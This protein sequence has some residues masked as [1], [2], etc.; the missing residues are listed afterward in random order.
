MLFAAR[1]LRRFL[2]LGLL[3]PAAALLAGCAARPAGPQKPREYLVYV[4]TNIDSEQDN[5]VF[6][7]RLSPATG[8]LT[9]VAGYSAGAKPTY[10]TLTADRRFLYAVSETGTFRGAAGGGVSALAVDRRTGALA[11]L[12]QQPSTGASPCYVSLDHT[13]KNLLVANYMGGNVAVLPVAADGQLGAPTATDQHTGSG[14]HKNQ[15]TPHAHCFLPDPANT[16]AF[17]ADLGTD[18]VVGYRLTPAQGQLARLPEPAFAAR[19]GAGPRHLVFHPNGRRAYLINELNSTLTT[20][21]YDPAAGHFTELQTVSALPAGYAGPNAC[22]DVH[23]G[24]DGRF[25]YASN[26]G[27]NSI[28]VFAIDAAAGTLTPVQDVDTQG[29][30]PRNFALDPSGRLLLVA[31]QNSNSV[32]TFRVDPS[33]G[34]LTPTGQTVSVPTP[35]VV[36][37]VEDFTR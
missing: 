31:N 21:A 36:Q 2:T 27:H 14:P 3:G 30:T 20:L 32:V 24:P 28:G 23:V 5:T 1:P 35:M 11:K 10:L 9:R 18:Q 12:N 4:G 8:A 25:L 29:Q 19:P 15:T 13:E 22:A 26:R 37:V 7:Y 33:S 34:R 6:L 16:F 17:A